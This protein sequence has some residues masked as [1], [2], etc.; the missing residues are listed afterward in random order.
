MAQP[1]EVEAD[2]LPHGIQAQAARHH[3]VAPKVAVEEPQVGVNIQF[4]D[5]LALVV[6]TAG[7]VNLRDAIEHQHVGSR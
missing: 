2:Q 4:G 6:L 5:Q 7:L 3:R 1:A